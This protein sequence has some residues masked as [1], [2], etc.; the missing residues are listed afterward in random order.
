[1]SAVTKF[2]FRVPYSCSTP[3]QIIG[4]WEARR[5][6]FNLAV[7]AA[8]VVTLLAT[9]LIAALPPHSQPIPL[10]P[11]LAVAGAYGVLANVCYTLGWVAELFIRRHASQ[12]LEAMGAA[13]FRYGLAFSVGLTLIPIAFVTL[14]KTAWVLAVVLY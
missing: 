11:S 13:L 8:G 6:P 9:H 2:L 7:G 14:L 4:W 10:F 5:F 3:A 12:D 1:M